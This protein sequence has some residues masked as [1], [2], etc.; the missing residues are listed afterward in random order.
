MLLANYKDP[1]T[2]SSQITLFCFS[3]SFS[4]VFALLINFWTDFFLEFN[5]KTKSKTAHQKT[6]HDTQTLF[7]RRGKKKWKRK[8]IMRRKRIFKI[9]EFAP[10]YSKA[11][12]GEVGSGQDTGQGRELKHYY[13]EITFLRSKGGVAPWMVTARR[14]N[15]GVDSSYVSLA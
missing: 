9:Q 12:T 5:S 15:G 2:L 1:T 11:S 7:K 13:L 10:E 3:L 6:T 14:R 8:N 4:L